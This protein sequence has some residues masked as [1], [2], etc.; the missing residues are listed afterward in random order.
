[1]ASSTNLGVV[2]PAVWLFAAVADY[3]GDGKADILL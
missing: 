2:N 3:N 1:V